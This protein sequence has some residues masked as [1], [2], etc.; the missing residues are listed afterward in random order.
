MFP[1][2]PKLSRSRKHESSERPLPAPRAACI[3]T[4]EDRR[5][6]SVTAGAEVSSWSWGVSQTSAA[7]RLLLPAVQQTGGTN[8]I[9]VLIG[10]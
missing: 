9:A 2:L 3:E 7:P 4:L 10:M 6:H 5:L 1:L 8:I